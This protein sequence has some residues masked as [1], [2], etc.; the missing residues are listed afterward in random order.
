MGRSIV[1]TKVATLR[2]KRPGGAPSPIPHTKGKSAET[3]PPK[4]AA[5]ARGKAH[6]ANA[7]ENATQA[8]HDQVEEGLS[9]LQETFPEMGDLLKQFD[10]V[11]TRVNSGG[12]SESP[13]EGDGGD[14]EAADEGPGP[15]TSSTSLQGSGDGLK[16]LER[17]GLTQ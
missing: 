10:Q 4:D 1:L 9:A 3:T 2:A 12:S 14:G 11:W 6:D 7:N 15:G 5:A 16:S 8:A 17:I 13:S